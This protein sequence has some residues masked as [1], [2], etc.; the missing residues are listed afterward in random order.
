MITKNW[1]GSSFIFYY[2]KFV[3]NKNRLKEY[4]LCLLASSD[5]TFTALNSDLY[6][7][8]GI[9]TLL[10]S[11]WSILFLFIN[12]I[13]FTYYTTKITI[14]NIL[15]SLVLIP[16]PFLYKLLTPKRHRKR[17]LISLGL[18]NLITVEEEK[19]SYTVLN[20]KKRALK[21]SFIPTIAIL[22]TAILLLVLLCD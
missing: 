9:V 7:L 5:L 18:D 22:T 2:N 14:L 3:L 15:T 10:N 1:I 17:R 20:L 4:F 12:G 19:N 16:L 6:F 13:I 21:I 11:T 8:R